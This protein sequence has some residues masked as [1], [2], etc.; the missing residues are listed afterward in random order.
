MHFY[1]IFKPLD[2]F[3]DPFWL[4]FGLCGDFVVL[5]AFANG[6]YVVLSAGGVDGVDVSLDGVGVSLDGVRGPLDGVDGPFDGASR[7]LDRRR[8]TRPTAS[9]VRS[10]D[11]RGTLAGPSKILAR[12]CIWTHF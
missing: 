4:P 6:L 2:L 11:R 9:A 8:G 1:F 3:L 5:L 10:T 12:V 7:D